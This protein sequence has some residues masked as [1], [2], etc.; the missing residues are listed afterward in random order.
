MYTQG[1]TLEGLRRLPGNLLDALRALAA[2]ETLRA[3]L[4]AA[5]CD[6]YL[7]LKHDEWARFGRHLTQWERETT[8]D[9]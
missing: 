7:K 8:L 9:C 1:H 6:S 2:D 3:R 5:F 4:G